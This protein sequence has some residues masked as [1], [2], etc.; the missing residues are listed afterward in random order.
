[1]NERIN[2]SINKWVKHQIVYAQPYFVCS[3][4]VSSTGGFVIMN[5]LR[6]DPAGRPSVTAHLA[7]HEQTDQ[8]ESICFIL[9]T[10]SL[11]SFNFNIQPRRADHDA[12]SKD[13]PVDR[14]QTNSTFTAQRWFR[15]DW[16]GGSQVSPWQ[17]VKAN[18]HLK[19]TVIKSR[20]IR[21]RLW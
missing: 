21:P 3:P 7:A 12:T 17:L 2:Q 4:W 8:D 18:S 11:L 14:S 5:A 13:V 15:N 19:G 16:Y 1:M 6:S 20:D 9:Q 10:T